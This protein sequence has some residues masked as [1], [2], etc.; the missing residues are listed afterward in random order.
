MSVAAKCDR[1]EKLYEPVKDG[2]KHRPRIGYEDVYNEL[3]P[4]KYVDLCPD[5]NKAFKRWLDEV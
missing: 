3:V 2:I 5:C 4:I 1:C